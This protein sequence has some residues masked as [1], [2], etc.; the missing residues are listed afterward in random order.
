MVSLAHKSDP[1]ETFG[2]DDCAEKEKCL[3][4]LEVASHCTIHSTS[5]L[6]SGFHMI[7]FVNRLV[8]CLQVAL[9]EVAYVLRR[10]NDLLALASLKDYKVGWCWLPWE[11][12][13][14]QG[15]P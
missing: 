12:S 8:F 1:E 9:K 6:C 15:L 5:F 10:G 13:V 7:L 4:Q 11:G 2:E 3:F 14:F